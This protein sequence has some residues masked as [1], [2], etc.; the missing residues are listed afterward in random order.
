M[1]TPLC[2]NI[3][4]DIRH[5]SGSRF[6]TSAKSA[7][8]LL[9][10]GMLGDAGAVNVCADNGRKMRRTTVRGEISQGTKGMRNVIEGTEKEKVLSVKLR[11]AKVDLEG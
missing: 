3:I 1:Q 2:G 8:L 11:E 10:H 4:T 7:L 9:S 5:V 6:D